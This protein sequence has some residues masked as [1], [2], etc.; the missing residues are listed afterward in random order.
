LEGEDEVE[1][2][3]FGSQ[4]LGLGKCRAEVWQAQELSMICVAP[5]RVMVD[6]AEVDVA[7]DEEMGMV[8]ETG[9]V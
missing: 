2:Q 3:R 9:S 5:G 1:I 4:V 7:D 8:L 6:G